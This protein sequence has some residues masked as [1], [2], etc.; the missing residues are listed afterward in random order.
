MSESHVSFQ[1]M[2]CAS[3]GFSGVGKT[4]LPHYTDYTQRCMV[5]SNEPL[6]V[7]LHRTKVRTEP[8]TVELNDRGLR[9]LLYMWLGSAS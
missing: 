9:G 6:N 4:Q 7:E 8:T 3:R 2:I 5:P 1:S